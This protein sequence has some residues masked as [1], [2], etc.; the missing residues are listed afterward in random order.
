MFHAFTNCFVTIAL[1]DFLSSSALKA[2]EFPQTSVS[3]GTEISRPFCVINSC[4][5]KAIKQTN[6][7]KKVRFAQK[8]KIL[9]HRQLLG[10]YGSEWPGE[11]ARWNLMVRIQVHTANTVMPNRCIQTLRRTTGS[12]C[13]SVFFFEFLSFVSK[14]AMIFTTWNFWNKSG[15]REWKNLIITFE[16][17]MQWWLIIPRTN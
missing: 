15:H 10:D 13:A 8:T 5:L 2:E 6:I 1:F 17:M 14:P 3:N 9:Y 16:K 4:F 7:L 11:N 12:V